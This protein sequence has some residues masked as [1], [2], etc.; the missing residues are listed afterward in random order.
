MIRI[1]I[2]DDQNTV[3]ELLKVNLEQQKDLQIVG[4]AVNGK[5]AI[6]KVQNLNPDIVLMDI[7]MP[8]MNG[9]RATKIISQKFV[10]TKVIVFTTSD[11]DKYL[12]FA[13]DVGAKGYLLKNT[14]GEE[15][16]KAIYHAQ[17]GYFY[18]ENK[19]VEKYLN[20][21]AKVQSDLSNTFGLKQLIINQA[22]IIDE[23]L[24]SSRFFAELQESKFTVRDINNRIR[25][26]EKIILSIRKTLN[27][28]II[29]FTIILLF[30]FGLIISQ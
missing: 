27:I 16:L 3:R 4:F 8:I 15:I 24:D 11:N 14:S 9:L 30:I 28:F 22:Q 25:N 5:D 10:N 29:S 2:V 23:K 1:L 26:L 7:N 6:Q 12:N 18:L 21:L 20:K 19:L 13:L 17:K